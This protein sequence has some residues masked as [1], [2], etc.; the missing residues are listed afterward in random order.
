[1][2]SLY[3][4]YQA[5]LEPLTQTQVVAYL[6]GLAQ[7]GYRM[8]LL[9]FEP[10]SLT[11]AETTVLRESLRKKGIQWYWCRY[12]K[13]PSLPA[14]AFDIFVGIIVG[15][16]LVQR[17][18]VR[19]LHAR[20]HV[21]GLMALVLKWLTGAKLLFD[22]RGFMAEEYVDAGRWRSGGFLFRLTKRVERA[23]VRGANGFVILTT[24]GK[25]LLQQWYPNEVRGKLLEVIPCCVDFRRGPQSI[26][27]AR[28]GE[29]RTARPVLAYVGK[30]GG[31]YLVEEMMAFAAAAMRLVPGTCLRVWTQS[32]PAPLHQIAEAAGLPGSLEI[33]T[34]PPAELAG[35]LTQ[36]HAGLAFIKPCTSKLA[37]SPTKVGEYLAA[38]LPVVST[39]GIGDTDTVLTEPS[40]GSRPVGVLVREFTPAAYQE[41]ACQLYELLADPNTP[42]RCQAA[43]KA[44]YD[45]DSVG[46]T[47]YRWLYHQLL[48]TCL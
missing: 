24:K 7:S 3:I 38:G 19:L 17:Y 32:D 36:V 43:A 23:L 22:I 21:P 10:R 4:C 35:A 20:A 14:T 2:T 42:A 27:C 28:V 16:W 45:L 37:S 39:A 13:W 30:L 6:E 5:I 47:R 46:W 12:H 33:G 41:A 15:F 11:A 25:N 1:M 8:L 26:D 18:H 9:T 29:G 31:W 44:H 48:G 34:L 40:K